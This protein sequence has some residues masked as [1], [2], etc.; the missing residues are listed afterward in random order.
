LRRFPIWVEQTRSQ[1]LVT[2]EAVGRNGL[3]VQDVFDEVVLNGL[4]E[5]GVVD[6][7]S[8]QR[9][10]EVCWYA[11]PQPHRVTQTYWKVVTS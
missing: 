4:V 3:P 1:G 10:A 8:Q 6:A 11:N 5:A 9:I 2:L 7:S